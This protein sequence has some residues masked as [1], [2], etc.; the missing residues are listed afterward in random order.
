MALD[1][2]RA[3]GMVDA[4]ARACLIVE[5]DGGA[6][7]DLIAAID[8]TAVIARPDACVVAA[9]D[10]QRRRIWELRKRVSIALKDRFERKVSEDI[11]VPPSRISEMI[12]RVERIAE[13][14]QLFHATYGHAGDGNLHTNYLWNGETDW[15]RVDRAL[16]AT[17]EA[18]VELSGTITGEHG[19]GLVKREFLSIEQ[20]PPLISLQRR[21]KATF[22]PL[23]LLNPGKLFPFERDQAMRG[24]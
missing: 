9:D 17:Y 23:G 11:C 4:Q 7:E 19:V 22:D 24:A 3:G 1:V 10:Q 12:A 2:V 8:R 6:G 14:E 15:A 18:A 21:M 16:R 5:L 20:A 13:R